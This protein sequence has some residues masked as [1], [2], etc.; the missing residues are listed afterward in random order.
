MKWPLLEGI[1]DDEVRGLMSIARRRR[2]TRGEVV[3]HEHD[4][5]DSLHLVDKGRF[6]VK[7]STPLGDSATL[8]VLGPGDMFG[9]LA[10]L[11]GDEPRR[12]A[13]VAALERGETLC[14]H[15]IDFDALRAR[16][17]ATADVLIQILAGQVRRLSGHLT[18]ALYVPAEKRVRRRLLEVAARYGDGDGTV[19]RD[20]V[21]T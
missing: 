3:F 8:A 17:P 18:E 14:V 1:A 21:Q 19:V 5:A 2:F 10:L 7:T 16:H 15:R 11:G 20:L 9:E 12:S 4:P 13:T 6:A